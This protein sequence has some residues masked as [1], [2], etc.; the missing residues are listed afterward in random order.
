MAMDFKANATTRLHNLGQSLWLDNITRGLLTSGTLQ[1]YIDEW[2]V[3]GLTSNP[4]I[5]DHAIENSHFYDDAIRQKARAGTVGEAL[6]FELALEDLTQ[7]AALFKPVHEATQGLDGWVSLEVSPLLASDTASTIKAA[8]DLHAR[9]KVANLLIKIPGTPEGVAAIE[10]SIAAG[11]PVNV[12]LLFSPEQY[13]AA[14]HAYMRGIERR[15]AAGLDPKVGSIASVFIS[16]WDKA[17]MD[18][19]APALRNTLGIAVAKRTYAAYRGL[20]DSPRWKHLS[21]AGAKPQ[22]LLWAST[23]TKDPNASDVLYIEALA[24]PDTINTI[25]DDTLRAFADHGRVAQ[26]M[27]ADGGDA[28]EVLARFAQAGVDVAA[29]GGRLQREGAQSFDDSWN[30]LMRRLASKSDAVTPPVGSTKASS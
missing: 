25:P 3:T 30:K 12:T 13:L 1:K 28:E 17:V 24:A 9:A 2:S 10:S 18:T 21:A 26:T 16:R 19:V 8:A 29:L 23:S 15:I 6:F 20:L 14:A 22:R 7:A 11:V 5:F 4:T 27:P